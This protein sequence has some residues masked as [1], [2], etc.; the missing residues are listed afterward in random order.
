M[1]RAG[2][3]GNIAT[4]KSYASRKFA[5]L[6][7]HV[8][9]ADRIGHELLSGDTQTCQ[10]IV[11]AFGSGILAQDGTIS[12]K[13]LGKVIFSDPDKRTVLNSL[14]HPVIGAEIKRRISEMERQFEDG[15]LIVEAALM[16]E[17]GSY[18]MY[19]RLIVVSCRSDLQIAR[20]IDRDHLTFE[21]AKA[22]IESQ[23]P[24]AEKLKLADYCIDT[25]GTLE[26]TR[27]QVEKVYRELWVLGKAS[28]GPGPVSP[29]PESK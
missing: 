23:M 1:I 13:K 26:Q 18:G 11:E 17:V 22:R 29:G 27:D 24:I 25:S 14:T 5:E 16:V 4:G 28:K 10:K 3:T 19:D 7:A 20:L 12:R 6:G 9:D 8:I 2:L 21:D 15:V